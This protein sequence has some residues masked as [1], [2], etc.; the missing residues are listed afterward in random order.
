[1]VLKMFLHNLSEA[2]LKCLRAI[3]EYLHE[4]TFLE[5]QIKIIESVKKFPAFIEPVCSSQPLQDSAASF[6]P[7]LFESS[8]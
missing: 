7:E 8:P 2:S 1:M 6:Y 3:N 5:T 4:A